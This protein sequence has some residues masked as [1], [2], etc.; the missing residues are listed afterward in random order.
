MFIKRNIYNLMQIK[1][2][3]KY[4]HGHNG[5][6]AGGC[7]K[8]IFEN[9]K[10]KDIDIFFNNESD[11][12]DAVE[13]FDGCE[14]NYSFYYENEKVKAYKDIS[15]G[16]TIE[17]V[18]SVFGTPEEII[19]GFDFTITKMALYKGIQISEEDL[20]DYEPFVNKKKELIVLHHKDYFEH[21]YLKRLVID[22]IIPFPIGTFERSYRYK[23]YGYSLCKES[24]QKLV[25]ALRELDDETLGDFSNSLYSGID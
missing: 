21:L 18:C 8:N 23:G 1:F 12:T 3:E 16:I 24:K 10:V 11:F 22:G 20:I 14:N 13:Y 17:L 7:F 15:T 9:Q 2:L 25:R 4:L 19:N 5:F 6:I